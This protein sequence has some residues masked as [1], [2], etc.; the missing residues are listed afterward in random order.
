MR[1]PP[2][3]MR[4]ATGTTLT[5]AAALQ[6]HRMR[7]LDL[8]MPPPRHRVAVVSG[9]KVAP[10]QQARGEYRQLWVCD[11]CTLEN[12]DDAGRCSACGSFKP[13]NA[14][15]ARP[16]LAQKIG[17]VPGPPPKLSRNQWE[18][19]EEAAE[20]RGDA[21][22]SICR[23][24][25]GVAAKV[26]LSC[27]HLFHHACLSSFERFMRTSA[28]VCPLCRKHNYEKKATTRGEAAF[29]HLRA[30]GDGSR[31]PDTPTY[32]TELCSISSR[33]VRAMDKRADSI[34]ALLAE[35]DKSVSLSRSVFSSNN[36]PV[37][38]TW[39]DALRKVWATER[40]E[41]ECPICLNAIESK[42]V[43]LLS[44]SHLLHSDCLCAFEAFNI[45][46]VHLCPVC[47][48]QYTSRPLQCDMSSFASLS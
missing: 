18:D 17:L 35:F 32:C 30:S 36:A 11:S 5:N 2:K 25:F 39:G 1:R 15:R 28:R 10:P 27:S 45:Y 42:A 38:D 9:K 46:E 12:D 34:D 31:G 16:T 7:S 3:S 20:A 21:L 13:N 41:K 44:C 29:R 33:I 24:P 6:D 8:R 48:G 23:E 40:D 14:R 19:C 37:E 26:I 43:T 47:R 22:C 4:L